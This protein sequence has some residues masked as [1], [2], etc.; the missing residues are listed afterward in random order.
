MPCR[1]RLPPEER[2]RRKK[3]LRRR[4]YY[5]KE[6]TNPAL[7][8]RKRQQHQQRKQARLREKRQTSVSIDANR[9]IAHVGPWLKRHTQHVEQEQQDGFNP[10][11][12]SAPTPDQA[13]TSQPEEPAQCIEQEQLQESLFSPTARSVA[14]PDQACTVASTPEQPITFGTGDVTAAPRNEVTISEAM[15]TTA[16]VA[17]EAPAERAE[18]EIR[19]VP[20]DP[21]SSLS[22]LTALLAR[23]DKPKGGRPPKR[24]AGRPRNNPLD[25]R[26]KE[27]KRMKDA[28]Q[29]LIHEAEQ[30]RIQEARH[31]RENRARRRSGLPE[32]NGNGQE[33][34][35]VEREYGGSPALD[36]TLASAAREEET[37]IND[38]GMYDEDD[39]N[40]IPLTNTSHEPQPH[41]QLDTSVRPAQA[42]LMTL[43]ETHAQRM[44][45]DQPQDNPTQN[46]PSQAPA[47]SR[48]PMLIK[49]RMVSGTGG[50]T[51][52]P[53]N[54]AVTTA[55]TTATIAS[56]A[57]LARAGAAEEAG[58]PAPAAH[59]SQQ[60]A[61]RGDVHDDD[62]SRPGE[63]GSQSLLHLTMPS[64]QTNPGTVDSHICAGIVTS[65]FLY[66]EPFPKIAAMWNV[67]ETTA[68]AICSSAKEISHNSECIR[69]LVLHCECLPRSG[70]SVSSHV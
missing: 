70:W 48:P 42:R 14:I 16:T 63:E 27:Y 51:A 50:A 17:E 66:S 58:N 6:K 64:L 7:L 21:P 59:A 52:A 45:Q 57:S 41:S 46:G 26:S 47:A 10:T 37:I 24:R 3:E 29:K 44:E 5:E 15:T 2:A 33:S 38:V 12:R 68:R 60:Q 30:K 25:E 22:S 4:Y 20:E 55:A 62:S 32:D 40:T 8:E 65:R 67:S 39:D 1:P 31:R 18:K 35:D 9:H 49:W 54:E 11:A 36:T 23:M 53:R 61:V 69:E 34:V 56:A 28:Q 19:T 13:L 43:R